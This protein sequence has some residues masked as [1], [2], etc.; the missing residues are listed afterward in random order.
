MYNIQYQ[1]LGLSL[2]S[3]QRHN[4]RKGY[5]GSTNT[6]LHSREEAL[7]IASV[8]FQGM[9]LKNWLY[10]VASNYR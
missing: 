7:D 3:Q 4:S 2:M 6:R 10:S 5:F 1:V 9:M 8:F